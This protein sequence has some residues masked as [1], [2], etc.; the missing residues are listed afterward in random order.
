[1]ALI[2][3]TECGRKFSDE[4]VCC[5]DCGCPTEIVSKASKAPD[6]IAKK[7]QASQ[8]AAASMLEEVEKAKSEADRAKK[9][10]DSRE[11][12]IQLKAGR[13]IDLFGGDATSRVAEIRADV[14]NAC[15][16]L[17]TTYQSLVATL[18][19]M[20]RPMLV[21]EPGG[22]AIEAVTHL[23]CYLNNESEIE[24]SFSASFNGTSLGSVANSKYLPSISSKMIQKFWES[25]CSS[26]PEGVNA[27]IKRQ[28]DAERNRRQHEL[29][30]KK[31]EEKRKAAAKEHMDKV[32][33]EYR[34]KVV[35]FRDALNAEISS[36][37][38]QT[39]EEL[40]VHREQLTTLKASLEQE[41]SSLGTFHIL[42]RLD[43]KNAISGVDIRLA[44]LSDKG[45]LDAEE[46][47]LRQRA[48]N[49]IKQYGEVI[50][51][52]LDE[53]FPNRD[54]FKYPRRD[55]FSFPDVTFEDLSVW[56][57]PEPPS[58]SEVLNGQT[59]KDWSTRK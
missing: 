40:E 25:Q 19:G 3:C 42:K 47:K 24:E 5:P 41:L 58:P 2:I 17:Y 6:A 18:D 15:S 49:A 33:T 23:I 38:K 51:R 59:E 12:D 31:K 4:A 28:K 35:S 27:A 1:M 9:L 52:Y 30:Q 16:D 26:S 44:E 10:F 14:R 55:R 43:K 32:V 11:R 57:C 29:E 8:Q 39:I 54:P 45:F 53:R 48:K 37:L 56:D 50:E 21:Y 46:A 13:K 22:E 7:R 36:K 20:C 34:A